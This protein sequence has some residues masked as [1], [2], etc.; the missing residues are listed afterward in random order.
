MIFPRQDDYTIMKK[1][2]AVFATGWAEQ[3]VD[4]YMRGI[5][6]GRF[7][8]I[9]QES[10]QMLLRVIAGDE[11]NAQ[12]DVLCEFVASESCGCKECSN[13]EHLRKEIGRRRF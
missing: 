10:V 11:S 3:M 8:K 13:V 5:R 6:D 9:G 1:K 2:I 4:E 12:R 7:D